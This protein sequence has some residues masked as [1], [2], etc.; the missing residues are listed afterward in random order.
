MTLDKSW[1]RFPQIKV[2]MLE[3]GLEL[4]EQALNASEGILQIS[5]A[6][7]IDTDEGLMLTLPLSV[8]VFPAVRPLSVEVMI[9]YPKKDVKQNEQNDEVAPE[10][11]V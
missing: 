3:N 6:S 1:D 9:P 10:V 7:W 5:K 11:Q 4:L 2:R 8:G